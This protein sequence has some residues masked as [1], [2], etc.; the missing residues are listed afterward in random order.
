MAKT[1]AP[2]NRLALLAEIKKRQE[3]VIRAASIPVFDLNKFCFD[4]QRDFVLDE[5]KFRTVCNSR[6]SGKSVGVGAEMIDTAKTH[7]GVNVLYITLNRLSAKRIIWKDLLKI[8]KE[9]QLNGK[10]NESELTITF[11]NNSVIYVSGAKDATEIEKFRGMALKKVF[12]DE[13]QSF[14]AYVRDLIDDVLVPALYDYDGSITLIG[15]PGPVEAGVFYEACHSSEWSNHHWTILD[16]P[17]IKAKSGKEPAV[18]LEQERKRRGILES[19]PTYMRES[20]GLWVQDTDSLVFKFNP[21]LNRYHNLPEKGSWYYIFGI[22]IGYNDADAIAVLGYNTFEKKVFLIEE[23][24]VRKQDITSLVSKVKRLQAKYEPIKMVMDAGALGKKIQEEILQRHGLHI[25]AAEKSR[26]VEFIEL[27]NDDLRT[28]KFKAFHGSRF[29]EDCA[30]VQWDADSRIKN[31][32]KPKIRDTYH[33][34]I[35]DAVLYAWRE[36]RHYQSSAPAPTP[37]RDSDAYMDN[38]EK[39]EAA[40]IQN[41]KDSPDWELEEQFED[42]MDSIGDIFEW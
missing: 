42:D 17:W 35:N 14:R 41:R 31:P 24:I 21:N 9:Y 22:D 15:T 11:P 29:E 7:D 39:A 2:I 6:R 38:L 40:K 8:N 12:I 4:K 25:E 27:L 30:L 37:M 5:S 3:E 13:A 28:S 32:D 19:D 26:K 18:I 34:D 10:I 1:K 20:L 36:C 16:N 23:S 33:S